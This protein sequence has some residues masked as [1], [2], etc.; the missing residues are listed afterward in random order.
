MA[1]QESHL[2]FAKDAADVSFCKLLSVAVYMPAAGKGFW[3]PPLV[4][5][6]DVGRA[7]GRRT[8]KKKYAYEGVSR[9]R[10]FFTHAL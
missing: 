9:S 7:P 8:R 10:L 4:P 1:G 3:H 5:R 2:S 6:T